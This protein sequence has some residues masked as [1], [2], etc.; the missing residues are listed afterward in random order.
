MT[1][2]WAAVSKAIR[3]RVDELGWRQRELAARSQVSQATVR[4]I[5]HH[6]AERRR[7]KR[8][9]EALS[10]ALGWHPEHLGA[11]LHHRRPPKLGEPTTDKSEPLA[12]SRLETIED[13]LSDMASQL[14]E[15]NA[16]IAILLDHA[17]TDGKRNV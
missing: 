1:E 2:D 12:S 13:R 6:T 16:N 3:K 9:L 5:Q 15:I 10:T 17:R 8:T 4:E 7:G 11:V 14:E